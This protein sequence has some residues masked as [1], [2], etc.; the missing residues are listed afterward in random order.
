MTCLRFAKKNANY[1]KKERKSCQN[2]FLLVLKIIDYNDESFK[3]IN[4]LIKRFPNI[5]QFCNRDVNK[6]VLLLRKGVYPYEY[7]DR[8]KSLMR[9]QY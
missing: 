4:G 6:V 3:P 1:A 9:H 2:V 8:R 5:Y 7:M